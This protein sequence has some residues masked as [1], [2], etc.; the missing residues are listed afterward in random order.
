MSKKAMIDNINFSE[1]IDT[2]DIIKTKDETIFII[3]ED[4]FPIDS[5]EGIRLVE[6]LINPMEKLGKTCFVSCSCTNF[7]SYVSEAFKGKV[8]FINS[9]LCETS[10][11]NCGSNVSDEDGIDIYLLPDC[12]KKDFAIQIGKLFLKHLSSLLY[13]IIPLLIAFINYCLTFLDP[14]ASYNKLVSFVSHL[15][16]SPVLY[17]VLVLF[18]LVFYMFILLHKCEKEALGSIHGKM[19]VIFLLNNVSFLH[20]LFFWIRWVLINKICENNSVK[21]MYDNN[22]SYSFFHKF[23]D[24]IYGSTFS[25]VDKVRFLIGI[26]DYFVFER[27]VHDL[28][29]E[30]KKDG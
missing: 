29:V 1:I 24:K 4:C 18:T 25:P 23:P 11:P 10:L 13:L 22:S 6:K 7:I 9:F 26:V 27:N 5:K 19:C 21:I 30:D 2:I 12:Q 3:L 8:K 15:S 17:A 14:E 20:A 16:S 28:P